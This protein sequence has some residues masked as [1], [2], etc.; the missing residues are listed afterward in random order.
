MHAQ[1][2]PVLESEFYAC[3]RKSHGVPAKFP[4]NAQFFL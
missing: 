4:V 3:F 2:D 1:I